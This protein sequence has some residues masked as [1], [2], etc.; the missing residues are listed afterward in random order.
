MIPNYQP[1]E[2]C[3]LSEDELNALFDY[4]RRLLLETA[5]DSY[6]RIAALDLL[7]VIR[8]ELK[9]RIDLR[10]GWAYP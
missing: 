3:Q 5:P 4:V 6:E 7:D 2:L 10:F 1:H 9:R 8:N